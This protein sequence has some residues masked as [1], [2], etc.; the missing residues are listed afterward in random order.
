MSLRSF[1]REPPPELSKALAT[2]T[3]LSAAAIAFLAIPVRK[4]P[5]SSRIPPKAYPMRD[6][7]FLG[8]CACTSEWIGVVT[9]QYFASSFIVLMSLTWGVQLCTKIQ[10][11][12]CCLIVCVYMYFK[13]LFIIL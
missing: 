3:E 5:P 1:D 11:N 8:F 10:Y 13:T 9:S 7:L 12:R 6:L 2:L 4:P